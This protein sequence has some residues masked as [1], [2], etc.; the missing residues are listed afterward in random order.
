MTLCSES[1][2]K[3]TQNLTQK[4]RE[5]APKVF[6]WEKTTQLERNGKLG[7]A[8]GMPPAGPAVPFSGAVVGSL[9]WKDSLLST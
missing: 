4:N 1:F 7:G 5:A 9:G 8:A 6:N 2:C 3:F